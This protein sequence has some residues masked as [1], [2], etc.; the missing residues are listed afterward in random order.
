VA[1]RASALPPGPRSGP[2]GPWTSPPRR[3][4][5]LGA[6]ASPFALCALGLAT[7]CGGSD[8][9][10]TTDGSALDASAAETGAGFELPAEAEAPARVD[11][12]VEAEAYAGPCYIET[13]DYDQ[14]CS[15]DSD[16]VGTLAS[17]DGFPI[18]SGDYCGN[19]CVCGGEAINK[20]AVAQFSEAV[21]VTPFVIAYLNHESCGFCASVSTVACCQDARC[22]T[23]CPGTPMD[24][25]VIEGPDAEAPVPGS[26]L[27]GLLS[28]P[29]DAGSPDSGPT[30]LCMPPE[31]CVPF[32][33]AWACCVLAG[34]AGG[35]TCFGLPGDGG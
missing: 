35:S 4:P 17:L 32:N 12:T 6:K 10:N 21:A 16:C 29:L 14:S 15:V 3:K 30:R 22:T 2:V 26:V 1:G 31:V 33:G 8:A 27:C 19:E 9:P 20:S 28:G 25:A 24:A 13:G 11:A 7:S 34:G 5:P 18:Q 23:R